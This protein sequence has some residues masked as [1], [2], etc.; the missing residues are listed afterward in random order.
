MLDS[1]GYADLSVRDLVLAASAGDETAWAEVVQRFGPFIEAVARKYHL[2]PADVE[3]VKQAVWVKLV[4]SIHRLRL[5]QALPGWIATTTTRMCI[6]V[7]KSSRICVAVDLTG[8]ERLHE[9]AS[10]LQSGDGGQQS[11]DADIER[12]EIR[13]MVRRG[14]AELTASERQLLLLLVADPRLTY[15][16]IASRMQM[17]VGSIGPTRSRCLRKLQYTH[18]FREMEEDLGRRAA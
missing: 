10:C 14:L 9:Q 15:V 13:R 11:A 2:A 6:D 4:T 16:Q 5:P 18:A 8:W 17:P 3:D 12:K 7:I 1:R